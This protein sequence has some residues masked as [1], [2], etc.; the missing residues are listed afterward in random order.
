ML[1]EAGFLAIRNLDDPR[2]V[3]MLR[4]AGAR[5]SGQ[6]QPSD[7]LAAAIA[8]GDARMLATL[9]QALEPGATP[10]NVLEVIDVYNPPRTT[11]S[12]HF[13]GSRVQFSTAALV[14]L[15]QFD[16]TLGNNGPQKTTALELLL[17]YVLAN[18]D[19]TDCSY[20]SLLDTD[21]AAVLFR[22]QAARA[23][24]P[25]PPLFD[26][27]SGRLRS[28]EFSEAAWA[29]MEHAAVRAGYMGYERILPP[30]CFLA[31]LAETEGITEQLVRLQAQPELSPGKVADVVVEALRLAERKLEQI[32]LTYDGIG[33][34]TVSLLNNAQRTAQLWNIDQIDTPHLLLALLG[35]IP[36]RLAF[37]LQHS[38]LN[39]NLNK[40]REHLDQ[41]LRETRT[42]IRREVAFRLPALLLPSEDLTYRAR[43]DSLL[44]VEAP[45]IVGRE[46]EAA[47]L[48]DYDIM[49]RA[50]YRRRNNHVLITGLRGVGKTT[51]VW[52]LARHAAL[53][54]IPFLKRKRFLWV[55]CQDISPSDSRKKFDVI[56]AH[57]GGR[58][59][60]I[61]CLDGLG[62]LLRTES[63]GNNKIALR[64]ALKEG[65]IQL[66][67]VMSNWDFEDLL[68]S[69]H[70]LLEFFTR[71][72]VDEPED[73]EAVAIAS[74]ASVGLAREYRV[75]I[76]Q[77][78]VE[79][80]V[81][82]ASDYILNERHP[83]KAIKILRRVCEDLDYERTQHSGTNTT[84]AA[85]AVIKVI[86]EISGVPEET[87]SGRVE[88]AN[89]EEDLGA[90]VVGQGEAVRA[91]ATELRL[92]KAG[93]TEPGKPAS[94]M[95]F[96]GMTGVGKT[97]LAKALA[98]FYSSSKRLQTYTMGNYTESHSVSAIIGVPPGYVGHE[99]GGRLI[100]DLNSD[101]YCV[102]LLDEAEKPHPDIWKPFLNLFDEGWIVDQRGVKAFADRAIFILTSNGG[103]EIISTMA[104][105]GEPLPR[106]V[107][108]VKEE[109]P[110]ILHKQTGQPVFTPEFLAR[111]KRIIVFKPLDLHAMEGI[112]RKLIART[113]AMWQEKRE[114]TVVVHDSLIGYI[115]KEGHRLNTDAS[116]KEG[117]RIVGK[118]I[119]DLIDAN[120]QRAASEHEARFAACSTIEL[121]LL[122]P[123]EV[124]IVFR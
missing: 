18:L 104:Q 17:S 65:R 86:A 67:G 106:I 87:L 16:A 28:D 39:L 57:I 29:V 30:H 72:V 52:D 124:S 115:A 94:V 46:S 88:K 110:R 117:G 34:T 20:L 13:D 105:R 96:A 2:A 79:R 100:N 47:Q 99:Q 64:G 83:A 91:V 76:E 33:E 77:R 48:K 22:E 27:T 41:H 61:L 11:P 74:Q 19:S 92:I 63:G 43:V 6:V 8:A 54:N 108:R 116:G 113:Q 45:A 5:A 31:L 90:V 71:V 40:L 89:Y 25:L 66:I 123:S 84:V 103:H 37:I 12:V 32:E 120:I 93:L 1:F 58:T 10:Q 56:L 69:D 122:L 51:L 7:L 68:A 24:A 70:E 75:T 26:D 49:T 101:P 121:A 97:E 118:L 102:F 9:S 62:P 3:A 107:E 60:L 53:G 35:E 36:P 98:R 23:V 42:L 95:L 59:D 21:R 114:K 109:L 81:A 78:A 119:S 4:T 15:D 38:P 112:C 82:L 73:A 50:L 44:S 85:P 55:D 111:I 80:A 14:A